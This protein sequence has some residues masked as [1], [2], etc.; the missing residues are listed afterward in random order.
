MVM[1]N[2]KS[3]VVVVK[4]EVSH[5]GGSWEGSS[6]RIGPSSLFP[7]WFIIYDIV[8]CIVYSKF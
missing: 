7:L 5:R 6:D 2:I 4:K 8:G 3:Q 1:I